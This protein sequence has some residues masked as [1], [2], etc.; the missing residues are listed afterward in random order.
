LEHKKP[1]L[2]EPNR[3]EN[4]EPQGEQAEPTGGELTTRHES[5]SSAKVQVEVGRRGGERALPLGRCY[6]RLFASEEPKN[7]Q[8]PEVDF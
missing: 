3:R 6:T 1:V 5:L 4:T 8:E 7:W 2:G